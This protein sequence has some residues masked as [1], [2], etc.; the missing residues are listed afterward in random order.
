MRV[1][2]VAQ[3]A[4]AVAGFRNPWAGGLALMLV[5]LVTTPTRADIT[6]YNLFKVSGYDQ[7]SDAQP[8]TPS[9]FFGTVGV[10]AN[11]P[12]DLAGGMVT[13]SSPLSPMTLTRGQPGNF[14]SLL[15]R[16]RPFRPQ[17]S[18]LVPPQ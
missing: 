7:T 1:Q 8:T 9:G 13:S 18:A 4:R 3:F 6:F 5:A 2:S 10:D 12:A 11:K 17:L 15:H 14:T 16:P